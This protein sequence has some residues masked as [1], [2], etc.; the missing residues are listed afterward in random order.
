M[1][2]SIVLPVAKTLLLAG[3]LAISVLIGETAMR[4]LGYQAIYDVYS[5]PS[6]LWQHD[7]LLGWSHEPGTQTRYVGPR[8]WPIEYDTLVSINSLGMRGPEVETLPEEGVRILVLGDSMVAGFEVEYEET[9]VAVLQDLLSETLGSPVQVLNG[10]VRGYGTD[11]SYLYFRERG[12]LLE[13]DIV[14]MFMSVNDLVNDVTIHRMRRIFGKP[15]FVRDE[16]GELELIGAPVP[17]Y[18]DCSEYRVVDGREIVRLDSV[19]GRSLCRVQMVLFDRSALFSFLT[20]LVPW[21]RGGSLLRQLYNAGMPQASDNRK[22]REESQ[23]TSANEVTGSILSSLKREVEAGGARFIVMSTPKMM[24]RFAE[25]GVAVDAFEQV[26]FADVEAADRL[27]VSFVHD[28]HFNAVG[29][30]M[31]AQRLH[32][33]LVPVI[34]ERRGTGSDEASDR[35]GARLIDEHPAPELDADHREDRVAGV[36]ASGTVGGDDPTHALGIE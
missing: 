14:L 11:Q 15:A 27:D 36:E 33:A 29:H 3:S 34:V 4:L 16:R 20:H 8:P 22:T 6:I 35:S 26:L 18:P 21:E 5:K 1:N 30:R 32:D 7:E 28:S 10:G 25:A 2:R 12:A 23:P 19:V 13:P 24:S 17:S 9:F 31:V